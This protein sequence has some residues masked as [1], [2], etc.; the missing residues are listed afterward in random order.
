MMFRRRTPTFVVVVGLTTEAAHADVWND[1]HYKTR[2]EAEE[3][4]E[5]VV[6]V[7]RVNRTYGVPIDLGGGNYVRADLIHSVVVET[8]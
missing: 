8:R 3:E 4:A 2:V 6:S 7:W 1:Q 5:R